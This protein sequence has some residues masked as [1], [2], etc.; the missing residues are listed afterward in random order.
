MRKRGERRYLRGIRE[1][2]AREG[3]REIQKTEHW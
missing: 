1:M 2:R 3:W